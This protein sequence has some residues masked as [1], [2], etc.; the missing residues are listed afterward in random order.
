MSSTL[1]H[2]FRY[3]LAVAV[4]SALENPSAQ[5]GYPRDL[6]AFRVTAIRITNDALAL[7]MDFE[8]TVK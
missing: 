1:A 3:P 5:P 6:Q 2:D 4:K 8:L 7:E